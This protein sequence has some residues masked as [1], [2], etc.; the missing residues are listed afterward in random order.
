MAELLNQLK[1]VS[2]QVLSSNCNVSIY[3]ISLV[4]EYAKKVLPHPDKALNNDFV[5]PIH[6]IFQEQAKQTPD[7]ITMVDNHESVTFEQLN[8]VSNQLSRHLLHKGLKRQ[9]VVTIFGHRSCPVV[10]AILST[11]KCGAI[12]NM[13]DPAY[14]ADRIITC[15]EVSTPSA[16]ILI[17]AAGQLPK[18]VIDFI[19]ENTKFVTVLKSMTDILNENVYSDY[20][21]SN[22]SEDPTLNVK[23]TQDDFAVCTYTSGST[24]IP[25]GVL[26][27]HG[28]LTHYY[29]WM[30]QYFPITLFH[31]P[32][33]FGLD[34]FNI[35]NKYFVKYYFVKITPTI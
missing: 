16:V 35:I 27:R 22:L 32:K 25:K 6:E 29:P 31:R 15:L 20:N 23:I 11:L 3:D 14:P 9:E 13:L 21:D 30:K 1:L 28:P 8:R 17:E 5:G 7:R 18:S 12:F 19:N 34:I 4:T 2:E 24:G 10:L 26:G 33:I